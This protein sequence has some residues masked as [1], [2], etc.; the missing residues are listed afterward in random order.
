[1][2]RTYF[3]LTLIFSTLL[4]QAQNEQALKILK[5]VNEK[6]NQTRTLQY[7][8]TYEGWGKTF[9]KFS[10]EVVLDKQQG[11]QLLVVLNTHDASGQIQNTEYIY[12]NGDQLKL[13]DTQAKVLK[14]GSVS[15]GS[16][17]LMSY[18]W[19][20]VFRE[21]LMPNAFAMGLQDSSLNYEGSETIDG[22]DCHIVSMNNPWG[23]RNFWY[24]GKSDNLIY[25]QFQ[26]NKNPDT[27]G[28]FVFK[29]SDVRIN[30]TLPS[31]AFEV[32]TQG[33]TVVDE[34]Q[35]KVAVGEQAPEWLL[36]NGAN[37]SI[38]SRQQQ[39]KL[40]LLDFWA[41]W[42]SPCW[43]IMPIIDNIKKDYGT[44]AL[45]VYGVN[46]WESPKVNIAD[47]LNRKN[48]N[49]YEVLFDMDAAVAKSFKIAALPLVVL[50]DKEGKILYINSGRDPEMDANLREILDRNL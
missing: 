37:E 48:L 12:T 36:K 26:E 30:A 29:M 42:C 16:Q 33:L 27:Q 9:G 23:D 15:G 6:N 45:D 35:R 43:Q 21:F 17:H 31:T 40:T 28:G 5:D 41:S 49:H 38:T 47:Y 20:A 24:F 25:G 2:K 13:A 8:Y 46:V 50:I 39:G 4:S 44:S 19:Y 22:T 10:G 18:A 3:F 34:N 32:P 7:S 14:K 1:M 11:L